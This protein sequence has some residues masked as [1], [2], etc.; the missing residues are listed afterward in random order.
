MRGSMRGAMLGSGIRGSIGPGPFD[1]RVRG[2][3]F[4]AQAFL[5]GGGATAAVLGGAD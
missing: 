1:P 5:V 3:R 2:E 4:A